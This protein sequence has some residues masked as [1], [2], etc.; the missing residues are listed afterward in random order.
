[1]GRIPYL[2]LHKSHGVTIGL[3]LDDLVEGE[4]RDFGPLPAVSA[5]DNLLERAIEIGLRSTRPVDSQ[6]D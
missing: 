4:A 5:G 6:H 2:I 1:M 3:A